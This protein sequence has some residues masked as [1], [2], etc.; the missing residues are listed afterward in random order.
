MTFFK[1]RFNRHSPYFSFTPETT[2][3]RGYFFPEGYCSLLVKLFKQL[4]ISC[5]KTYFKLNTTFDILS[6]R[7]D[8]HRY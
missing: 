4:L 6:Q 7:I 8:Q 3:L 5:N 1:S 2:Y